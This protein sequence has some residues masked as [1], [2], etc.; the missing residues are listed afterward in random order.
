M[1]FFKL[2][3]FV[4]ATIGLFSQR[5]AKLS[6]QQTDEAVFLKEVWP[7]L[8]SRC[9]NC[10]NAQRAEGDL[11]FDGSREAIEN[12]GH[13]GRAVLGTSSADSELIRRINSTEVGY[14]MP[15]KG[16]PLTNEQITTLTRWVDAGAVWVEPPEVVRK[17]A[18][19][20][21]GEPIITVADRV[22]WFEKQMEHPGF[23][24]L[25]Y[26][27]VAFC[28]TMLGLIFWLRRSSSASSRLSRLKTLL[29][30]FLAFFCAATYIHYD[31]KHKDAVNE[32]D[33]VQTQLLTYTGPPAFQQ[34][35]TA[36]YPMHPP[37]LGGVY[38]R[39]NDERDAQ[40]F[41]GGFYRT[42]QFEV[43]LTDKNGRRLKWGDT[44]AGELFIEF[45]I[46]RA[47]NTTG[48]LFNDHIMSVIGLADRFELDND[49]ED[50]PRVEGFTPMETIEPGQRWRCRFPIGE[51]TDQQE[52]A[53]KLFVVQNTS[54]PKAHYAIEFEVAGDE[55]GEIAERSQLWMG[56][57][58]NLNG[59]VFVPYDDQKILLD[60]WFDW[61]PIPEV[62]G[63]QTDDPKLLG[64]PE[65][66]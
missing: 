3:I 36:P 11:R 29:I 30:F 1:N 47:A 14:R 34:S 65:H 41:N 27:A 46:Q 6:A 51:W 23:R 7:I 8:Q 38:Y 33:V 5:P 63:K 35:L 53:G 17:T 24:G 21:E 61:R 13:T 48:E 49:A 39:G 16:V 64:I 25:V 57:L 31:A 12:G 52:L 37:R 19:R 58:Y 20:N 18:D 50:R 43:W 32:L 66:Q 15:K 56:S 45:E 59:R 54:K 40:L 22:V 42:A 4:V 62:I 55:A 10:H 26:L 28:A 2:T 60:R 44:P 9:I